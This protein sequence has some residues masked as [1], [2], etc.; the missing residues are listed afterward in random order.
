MVDRLYNSEQGVRRPCRTVTV[1]TLTRRVV[2]ACRIVIQKLNH[3]RN[4]KTD[5]PVASCGS[6]VWKNALP[7][8]NVTKKV[9]RT[10]GPGY[11]ARA[12]HLADSQISSVNDL[13]RSRSTV[14]PGRE[15][16]HFVEP[17]VFMSIAD[18][19]FCRGSQ[20]KFKCVTTRDAIKNPAYHRRVGS[21]QFGS[22]LSDK[23]VFR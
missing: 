7:S 16:P 1:E 2:Y 5:E 11:W 18:V 8:V 21:Q 17:L 4:L 9:R 14:F 12:K 6:T 20:H 13:L 3:K 22:Y 10:S 23:L 19:G 15:P